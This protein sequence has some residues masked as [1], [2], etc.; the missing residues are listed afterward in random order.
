M[1]IAMIGLGRMGQNM[2]KRLIDHGHEVIAYDPSASALESAM[3]LGAKPA[4]D[5]L[6]VSKLLRPP[7]IA[8]VM[9]PHEVVNQVIP[10]LALGFGD[11]DIIIDGGNSHFS[12]SIKNYQELKKVNI[13]FLDIGV[14]GGI[15]GLERGY[16]LMVGGLKDAFLKIEPILKALAPKKDLVPQTKARISSTSTADQG[17]YYCGKSGSGHYAKMIHNA[18]EYGMMQSLAEGLEILN[19]AHQDNFN[20]D[21]K[22]ICELWRRGSVISSWLLDLMTEA[23]HKDEDLKSF[24]GNVPDSGEGRWALMEAIKQGTPASVLAEALFTRF[25]SRQNHPFA[26]KALSALR[27]EFGGHSER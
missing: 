7:K 23:L 9:V 16:C 26:E 18:I 14:S 21:L 6:E 11:G 3:K 19:C 15:Y 8:W 27:K 2:A 10:K 13:N 4:K 17:Y 20:F 12:D 22:E 25:R 5:L 24:T 1:Q